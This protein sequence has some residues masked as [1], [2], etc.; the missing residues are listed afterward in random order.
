MRTQTVGLMVPTELA[1]EREIQMRKIL[2]L[3]AAGV[4]LFGLSSTAVGAPVE[5]IYNLTAG[6]GTA[7]YTP[8][9]GGVGSGN[10]GGRYSR[11]D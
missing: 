6:T 8:T 7:T 11:T 10:A 5:V 9:P 4:F 2:T 3:A 1:L